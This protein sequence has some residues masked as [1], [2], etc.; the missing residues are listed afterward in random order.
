MKPKAPI[1]AVV[2]AEMKTYLK[3]MVICYSKFGRIDRKF[4]FD[5]TRAVIRITIPQK[6]IIEF[7]TLRHYFGPCNFSGMKVR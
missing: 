5:A 3:A 1:A 2:M 7:R 4:L 6:I